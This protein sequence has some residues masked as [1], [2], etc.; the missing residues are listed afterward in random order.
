MDIPNDLECSRFEVVGWESRAVLGIVSDGAGRKGD[1]MGV[2]GAWVIV[3]G[4]VWQAV[5]ITT[6]ITRNADTK[7]GFWFMISPSRFEEVK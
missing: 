5:E 7:A 4:K 6:N 3:P 1:T 2:G